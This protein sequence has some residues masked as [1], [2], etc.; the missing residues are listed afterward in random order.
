MLFNSWVFWI[1]LAAV[2]ICYWSLP[3]RLQNRM[4]LVASYIFYGCWSFRFLP[5]II[6]ST[7][8]DYYLGNAVANA[9]SA[10]ARRS[11]ISI[12]VIV[13]LLLLAVFKYCGFFSQELVSFAAGLGFSLPMPVVR[14][15][16]PV[17]I[18]FYTFQSMAYIFDIYRGKSAPAR[19]ILDFALYIAFFPH[20]VAGPIMRSG[21]LLKQV[22]NPRRYREGDFQEGLYY[23]VIG[24]LKKIA[25]GD[26]MA[27]V[28][29]RA[30]G[31]DVSHLTGPECIL[32]IYAFAVQIY[33]DFSGYS[34]IAQGVAKW[35][36]FDLMTNFRMP[37]FAIS[38]SDFWKHWHISLS[39]WLRDYLYI[40]LGGNRTTTAKI[41]RNLLLTMVIGGLWHGANWTFI[42]W[43]AFHGLLLCAYRVTG[44]ELAPEEAER[45]TP[46]SRALRM[47]IMFHLVCL[48]WLF[49]R[50]NSVEQAF[51]MLSAIVMRPEWTAACTPI[52]GL[53]AFYAVPLFA[54]E[55]WLNKQADEVALV[56]GPWPSRGLAYAYALMM[57]VIFPPSV[58]HEFIY[59]QF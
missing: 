13:N 35:M 28:V 14:L 49:F 36:G 7:I 34:S 3:H 23:I 21:T 32:A 44:M 30:F 59:F 25:I 45:L 11:F 17:G 47:I 15:V 26:N 6:G 12:S 54:Y 50:A 53:I 39:T 48:G 5:L 46:R 8:M 4:L 22:I 38:P 29:N 19:N 57:M 51:S 37:Y 9:G 31:S 55:W 58:A 33:C 1:F 56:R 16:L 27:M 24:L 20:L 40:G 52:A 43:G 42:V 18:S 2:L 10:R 41:Y